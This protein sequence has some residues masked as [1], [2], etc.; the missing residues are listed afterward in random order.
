MCMSL[1]IAQPFNIKPA[2]DGLT[3]LF[4][5]RSN[6]SRDRSNES[7]FQRF[8]YVSSKKYF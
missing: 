6:A 5:P 4:K 2:K 1:V 8:I 7:S 3:N